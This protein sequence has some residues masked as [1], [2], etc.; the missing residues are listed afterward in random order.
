MVG[1]VAGGL[2]GIVTLTVARPPF[3]AIAVILGVIGLA[4][5]LLYMVLGDS[6]P[7]AVLGIGGVERWVAYPVLIWMMSFG[8]YL[9]GEARAR[10]SGAVAP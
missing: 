6:D 5:L 4:S 8:G 2:A 10:A 7:M 9:M 1:F 3:G